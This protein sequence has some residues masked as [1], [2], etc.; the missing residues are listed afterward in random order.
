MSKKIAILNLICLFFISVVLAFPALASSTDGT[1]DAF[2][3]YAW[4]ENAGWIDFGLS[5]GNIHVTDSALTGY[6]YGEN[7]GWI[8]LNCL[9]DSSCATANYG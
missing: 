8:S 2:N 5:Q 6:V 4:S 9:N 1:I 3:K 7:I